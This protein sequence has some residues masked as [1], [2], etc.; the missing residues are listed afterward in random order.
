MLKTS[1]F[2]TFVLLLFGCVNPQPQTGLKPPMNADLVQSAAVG[3][4]VSGTG[5]LAVQRKR[6]FLIRDTL[7]K[8]LGL[9]PQGQCLELGKFPCADVVHLAN[10]GGAAAYT[11]SQYHHPEEIYLSTPTSFDRL[12]LSSCLQRAQMDLGD[13]EHA[14]IFKDIKLTVDGRLIDD[15]TIDRALER[16]YQRGL[17]RDPKPSEIAALRGFYQ[18]VFDA[19]PFG[20]AL[21]WMVLSC[22]SVLSSVE[23]AFF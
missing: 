19:E 11:N 6:A 3:P 9:H 18:Q 17:Q 15:P 21:N 22:F 16:L 10:L 4:P 12:V 23:S 7:A 1:V 13:R 5:N 8:A 2:M 20:A 14:L